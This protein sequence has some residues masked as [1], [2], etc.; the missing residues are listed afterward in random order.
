VAG[1]NL[2]GGQALVQSL[3]RHGVDAIFGLPGVQLDNTF[4]A[5]YEERDSIR[6]YHTRHE[7]ATSYMA[8]GYARTTGKPGVCLVVP[9]PGLLNAMAGL[10]TAYACN[11]PVLCIS[12]QI[13]SNLIGLNRGML[14]EIPDQLTAVKSVTKWQARIDRPE[15]APKLVSEAFRQMLSGR[16]RPVELEMAP[17]IMGAKADVELLDPEQPEQPAG[18]PD[19][20]ERAAKAL[21]K[22]K[23]PVIFVGGGVF[24]AT[25]ELLQLADMLQAPVVMSNNGK[26]AVSDKHYLAQNMIAGRELWKDADVVLAVGTRFVMPVTMWGLDDDLTIIQMDADETEIGRNHPPDIGIVADAKLGLSQLVQRAARHNGHRESREDELLALKAA[27]EDRMYEIQPQAA[28]AEAIRAELPEDG[29]FVSEMTQVGY[30]SSSGFPVYKPRSFVTAGYQGTLG[31][32]YA[33]ALG[34][35][36]ANPGTRVISI[37][38][39]G[40]FMYNVQELST[41][42]MHKIPLTAI[43]FSDNAF[44]NVKRI[45]QESYGGRTIASDLYNPDF[46]KLADSFGMLGLRA[47]TPDELRGVIREAFK[48]DAPALIEVPVGPMPSPSRMMGW[49]APPARSR[50]G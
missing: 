2:T 10:S 42:V 27:V 20:I 22:A 14:H 50:K 4:D 29:I 30:W 26:G 12:G 6:V 21:A 46:V 39:D 49:G 23:N 24:G 37:N 16:R 25:D 11:S 8:D 41:A 17:D 48:Q 36:I 19:K 3:K 18:D 47:E 45:Q 35:Q 15:D 38:G 5:L 33:T 9:G 13:Q 43:V 28:F 32:G 31:Y 40:G 44:G 1:S 7:Q 34:A